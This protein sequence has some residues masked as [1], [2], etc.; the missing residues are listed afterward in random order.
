M[1]LT[2]NRT[3]SEIVR[4]FYQY[5]LTL[6]HE[7]ATRLTQYFSP[8]DKKNDNYHFD[9]AISRLPYPPLIGNFYYWSMRTPPN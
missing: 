2:S 3:S 9:I 7:S 6:H 4:K 1:D 8:R 5:S